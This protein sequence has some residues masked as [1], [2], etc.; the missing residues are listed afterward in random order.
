ME[1]NNVHV[2]SFGIPFERWSR[3]RQRLEILNKFEEVKSIKIISEKDLYEYCPE[4]HKH[5]DFILKSKKGYGYYI[6]KMF[7]TKKLMSFIPENDIIFYVDLGCSYNYNENSKKRFSDYCNYAYEHGSLFFKLRSIE[8]KFTKMDTYFR[9]F[10]NDKTHLE[11]K[12]MMGGVYFL[13]NIEQN[14]NIINEIIDLMTEKNYHYLD[15]S[16]SI[17][18]NEIIFDS[19]RHD[20]S[21]TSLIVKKYNLYSINDETYWHPNW[22]N[23]INYPIMTTRTRY[24]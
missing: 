11:S 9:V 8:K 15:D 6:W 4:I 10:E 14:K 13:K 5:K 2:I 21:I 23:G 7:L 12:Q 19:H 18:K 22:K 16:P 17:I 24:Q 3:G 1:K 20:Q